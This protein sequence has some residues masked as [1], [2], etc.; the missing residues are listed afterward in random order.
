MML[1]KDFVDEEEISF[2]MSVTYWLNFLSGRHDLNS[3]VE[4][5]MDPSVS[6]DTEE[7]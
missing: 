5:E 7:I 3:L 1:Q 4:L 2:N 6:P